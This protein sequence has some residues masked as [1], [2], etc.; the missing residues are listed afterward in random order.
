MKGVSAATLKGAQQLVSI[1]LAVYSLAQPDPAQAEPRAAWQYTTPSPIISS[2]VS[3]DG[4]VYFGGLDSAVYA[5]Q[6]QSGKLRWRFQTRGEIRSTPLVHEGRVY[7]NGGDGLLHALD[8]ASGEPRWE[9]ATEGDTK[10]DF[11]DYYQSSP[12]ESNGT[13]FF[14]SGDRHVYAVS[15]DS[16]KLVWKFQTGD[17]VHATPAVDSGRV[18]VGSFDGYFYALNARTGELVWKF[19]SVGQ[20]YFPT[21]EFQGSPSVHGDLVFVGARD[22][23]FYALD[24]EKGYCHWNKRFTRGWALPHVLLDTTLYI[25]TSDDRLL[26]AVRPTSGRE[27]WKTGLP[28]NIFGRVG[29]Q[30]SVGYVGT[31]QGKLYGVNLNTGEV[32]WTFATTGYEQNHLKYFKE[33]D[34]FRDDIFS[35]VTSDA[36][37][38]DV[39]YEVGAIFSTPLVIEGYLVVT[40]TDGRVYAFRL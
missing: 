25:G 11:A 7:V 16:G 36:M 28:F 33:D 3:H 21:G 20:F 31:L 4:L 35:F 18:F 9:F 32:V 29:A 2:P 26:L 40:S 15:A 34:S 24:R 23:N 22:F 27:Y 6:L 37:F 12:V 38:V 19:K 5:V 10:H 14:G 13:L 17:V 8:A 30:D 1:A 39:E